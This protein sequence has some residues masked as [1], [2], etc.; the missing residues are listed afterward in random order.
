VK[1]TRLCVAALSAAL[2]FQVPVRVHA[3]ER[4][5]DDVQKLFDEEAR[6]AMGK[7]EYKRALHFF[8]R[9][10]LID[11]DD[12]TALREAG[13][14]AKA[15]GDLVY[16][17]KA[18]KRTD[19]LRGGVMDPELHFL[20]GEALLGLGR[21]VEA[22][23]EFDKALAELK[24]IPLDRNASMWLARI[25]ALKGDLTQSEKLYW[26]LAPAYS[27]TT[28]FGDLMTNLAEA[29]ILGNDWPG[30]EK[31]LRRLL[32]H[33]PRHERGRE[34]LAWVLEHKG[35][36]DAELAVREELANEPGQDA[37]GRAE[38]Y[39]RAL[40][41]AHDYQGALVHYRQA[42]QLG[43]DRLEQDIERVQNTMSPEVG[44]GGT[45]MDDPTG[46]S[47][48]WLWG[49]T[50]PLTR[51]VRLA[52]SGTYQT[53]DDMA[54]Q[55]APMS[56]NTLTTVAG[57]V[58]LDHSGDMLALGST[59]YWH[60]DDEKTGRGYAANLRT[61]PSRAIQVQAIGEYQMP[62]RESV[63]TIA[64]NGVADTAGL[65]VYT[66][67]F[68]DRLVLGVGARARRLALEPMDNALENPKAQQLFGAAG[69]DFILW[70]SPEKVAR[71]EILDDSMLW[72]SSLM[73]AAVLSYRHYELTSDDPFGSRL[74]LVERSS[75]DEVSGVIRETF[76]KR[77]TLGIELRGG[78][79][80]DWE[81][82]VRQWRAGG[83]LLF[84][85]TSNS[86]LT[87]AYDAASETGTG[88]TGQRHTGWF[89]LHVDL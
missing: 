26:E 87:L 16:A 30:A 31:L 45:F 51:H 22:N 34:M 5:Y 15:L 6:V 40:E 78:A 71:G 52:L 46:Q 24:I 81:R 63:A 39:G 80:Y 77:G 12:A 23:V 29:H 55:L 69:A 70:A 82:D 37:G 9:L 53:V 62:W 68:S 65:D 3:D 41:R 32:M 85:A 49:V 48:G 11:P 54:F 1:M 88:L 7:G 74:V 58:M 17:E 38:R 27:R 4:Q 13:R 2:L 76:G 33:Q 14:C 19:E 86:R 72:P 28:E 35:D 84:A 36:T 20:R 83:S 64:M 25:Y 18:L 50:A 67:P 75:L 60:S 43:N 42:Q 66:T 56:G 89:V 73:A 8:W 10:L 79:G 47:Q 59:F 61:R 44:A 21:K 57:N